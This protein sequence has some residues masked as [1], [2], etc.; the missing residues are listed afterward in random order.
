MFKSKNDS[1]YREAMEQYKDRNDEI[2]NAIY[3]S[4]RMACGEDPMWKIKEKSAN[5]MFWIGILSCAISIPL[6]PTI[7]GYSC[8]IAVSGVIISIIISN[9]YYKKLLFE[10]ANEQP[11]EIAYL[12]RKKY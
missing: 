12:L 3:R 9:W 5:I 6:I 8:I 10:L 7:K 4:V 1:F 11:E 2:G